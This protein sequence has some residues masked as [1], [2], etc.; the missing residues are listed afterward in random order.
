MIHMLITFYDVSVSYTDKCLLNHVSFTINDADK[1]GLVGTNG[2]GKSTLLKTIIGEKDL[3]TGTIYKKNGLRIAY[4]SQMPV[5]EETDT[6][7]EIAKKRS[8]VENEYEIKSMLSKLGLEKDNQLVCQL[9]GGEKRRLALAITLVQPCDLLILDEPTNHLDIWMI[10]WLEKFLIKW[11]KALL[12]V[13]HDRYFLERIT[14]KTMDL[15]SGNVYIYDANYSA[16]L[17]LKAERLEHQLAA[18]RKLKAILKQEATWASLNPQARSTKSKERLERFYALE[19]QNRQHQKQMHEMN[20]SIQFTSKDT[21]LGKKT[22]EIVNLS[23]S[24]GG[25]VL[26]QQFSYLVKRFD[27]LGIVGMNGIGKTTLFRTILGEISPDTGSIIIGDTVKVGYFRQEDQIANS[28][29]KIIDY[30]KQFG[31]EIETPEGIFTASQLLESF[32][33]TKTM[34]Y[35]SVSCLSGGEKRRLQLLTILIQNPNI[36]FLDEPTNDL[37]LYTIELLEDYLE[38][39]KGAVIVISHDRYFLDKVIQHSFIYQNTQLV[40][41][42]GLISD[43]VTEAIAKNKETKTKASLPKEDIPRFTSQEKKEFDSIEEKIM[44]EEERLE[45]LKKE[46]FLCGSDYQKLL[47]LNENIEQVQI[48]LEQLYQ[49]YTYLQSIHEKIIAYQKEKYKSE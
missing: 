44:V 31:E 18:N 35:M 37:D 11:N 48:K 45:Q 22:I 30:L 2:V 32:L 19:E 38:K 41:Y 3:L 6:V 46:T 27:R 29:M 1:I 36:L 49:R 13:T 25:K 28:H 24:I 15:E 20:Q 23:K 43:Y 47:A 39:F 16:Y 10:N 14:H 42:T 40:E 12:L 26:F 34:Q 4:L 7:L 33:F 9:S 5:F 8:R 17:L 21:R